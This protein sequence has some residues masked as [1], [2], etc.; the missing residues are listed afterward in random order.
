MKQN[1]LKD[2]ENH[3]WT[4]FVISVVVGVITL[5]VVVPGFAKVA[6]Y[7]VMLF[8]IYAG[9]FIWVKLWRDSKKRELERR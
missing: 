7:V 9:V 8:L 4:L 2:K 1:P 3:L 6:F 5:L